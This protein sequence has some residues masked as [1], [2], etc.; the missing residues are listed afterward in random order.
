MVVAAT[1]TDHNARLALTRA[2]RGVFWVDQ[3]SALPTDTYKVLRENITSKQA[4]YPNYI[5]H[6]STE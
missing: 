1:S 3:V 5:I 2:T 4:Q 6:D